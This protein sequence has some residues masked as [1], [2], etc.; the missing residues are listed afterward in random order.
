MNLY[1][2]LRTTVSDGLILYN[3]GSSGDFVA[4]E[5]FNGFIRYVYNLGNGP[6]VEHASLVLHIFVV[7]ANINWSFS[8]WAR[9]IKRVSW[10]EN[11]MKSE[12]FGPRQTLTLFL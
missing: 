5:L 2:T 3:A 11:G 1:F 7:Y 10:M 9:Q 4:V 12:S 8:S 6:Q